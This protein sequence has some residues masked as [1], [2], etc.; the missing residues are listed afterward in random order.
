MTCASC[1]GR[2]GATPLG[3]TAFACAVPILIAIAA[4]LPRAVS[5][6]TPSTTV[7]SAGAEPAARPAQLPPAASVPAPNR[8]NEQLPSWLRLR[9]E[10][11]ERFEAFDGLGFNAS[12]EDTYWLSR[13]R[14]NTTVAP[15]KS[16][17]FQ[18][19]LQDSRVG[20][21]SVGPTGPP[22]RAPFD[23]RTG[24]SDIGAESGRMTVRV[25]RQELFFGEQRLVGHVSWLNS[26]R[27]FDGA[28]VTLRS[29]AMRVDAFATSVVR[30]IEDGF[31]TSGHG[32]RF[33]GAYGASQTL[34][35][36]GA[37]E[38]YLFWR[39][40]TNLA[41][42]IGPAGDLESTTVGVRFAGR[43]P[44]RLD[45]GV[46]M[47]LQRGSLSGDDVEAWGG[48]WQLRETLPGPG[49]M[50]LTAE[51]NFASGDADPADGVRG[52]FD[53]LYPTPHDKYGLSDQIGWK[54]IH[55]AR[56][57]FDVT[58]IK[59]LPITANY[60]S[61]WLADT[62]DGL[63]NAGSAVIARVPGGAANSHVGQELDVQVSRPL[64]PQLQ[65]AAGYAYIFPGA[66]LKEATPGASYS[67]PY[68]MVTYVFL[69]D[70]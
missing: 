4:A 29:K 60:H 44:A 34:I 25:G 6:Q 28:R 1:F 65:L 50:K 61:W 36:Q 67:Y 30:I 5:A 20:D 8:V 2:N 64:F 49:T 69:A 66:F 70:K 33:F 27:T 15:S 9:A 46:E 23:L 32:N 22:F 54:N 26:A 52:T 51:Y 18:V 45:Y 63:Y 47:A 12:R 53:Q 62:R 13:F 41:A 17:S 19:Q 57:G 16:L 59:G 40:D 42:E 37:V 48:H 3:R 39:R 21:K 11:R 24:F 14:F 38:P 31:D 10:F 7:V 55:H 58:P 56:A 68:V 43:L 35:P